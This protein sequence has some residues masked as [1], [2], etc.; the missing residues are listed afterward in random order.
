MSIRTT[1]AALSLSTVAALA[2]LAAPSKSS[3]D[4]HRAGLGLQDDE[5]PPSC[6]LCG[7][8][9]FADFAALTRLQKHAAVVVA[10]TTV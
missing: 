10:F 9:N 6:P 5:R 3:P 2:A 1:L 4:L 8:S 7:G